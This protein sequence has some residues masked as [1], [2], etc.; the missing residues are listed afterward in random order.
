MSI[1]KRMEEAANVPAAATISEPKFFPPDP[2]AAS[3]QSRVY[4]DAL[5]A[6]GI[7]VT[8]GPS[9]PMDQAFRDKLA[10]KYDDAD[11]ARLAAEALPDQDGDE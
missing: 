3:R 10:Q 6:Q 5:K 11:A 2:A 8:V 1:A 4:A 9:L 7:T